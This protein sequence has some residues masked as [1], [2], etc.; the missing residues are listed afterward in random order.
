MHDVELLERVLALQ[1]RPNLGLDEELRF[2]LGCVNVRTVV[3]KGAP[4]LDLETPPSEAS[5]VVGNKTFVLF[6]H[7]S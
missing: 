6:S 1:S 7:L 4:S 5:P 3:N 2:A